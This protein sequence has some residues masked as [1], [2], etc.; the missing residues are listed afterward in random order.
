MSRS[1]SKPSSTS[2]VVFKDWFQVASS[3][4]RE[5][6]S[7]AEN[8]PAQSRP[9]SRSADRLCQ[10]IQVR[11]GQV[12]HEIR[13]GIRLFARSPPEFRVG[14][15]IKARADLPRIVVQQA[16]AS[17]VQQRRAEYPYSMVAMIS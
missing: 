5:Q 11:S 12:E 2:S 6:L 9:T 1:G 8:S 7:R 17:H 13:D 10:V 3:S 15:D 14:Q 4:V 16:D